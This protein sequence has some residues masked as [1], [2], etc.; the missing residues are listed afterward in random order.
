LGKVAREPRAAG[1]GFVDND[2][3]FAFGL[4]FTDERLEVT[5]ARA[6]RA[7]IDD[8][9]VVCFGDVGHGNRL[10]MDIQTDVECA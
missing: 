4:E 5:L 7:Q 6:E 1:A 3:M 10:F 2:E 8:L 9:G